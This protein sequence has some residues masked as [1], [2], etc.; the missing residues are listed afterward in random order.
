MSRTQRLLT[1]LA[2]ALAAVGMAAAPA[3]AATAVVQFTYIQYDSPGSDTGTNAS[4]N[5]EYVRVTNKSSFRVL[6]TGWTVR[7]A[8]SHVYTFQTGFSLPAGKTVIV[9]TG[10]GTNGYPSYWDRY[11]QR[12]YYVWNNTG[13]TATLKSASGRIYDVCRWYSVGTGRTYC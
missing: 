7:D 10:K 12:G 3:Q 9:H 6:M 1:V 8:Q 13:D 5:A 11:Q 4:I 2:V